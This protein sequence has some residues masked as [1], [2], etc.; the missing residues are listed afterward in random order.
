MAKADKTIKSYKATRTFDAIWSNLLAFVLVALWMIPVLWIVASAFSTQIGYIS[1]TF[2]PTSW[3]F[4]NFV[5]LFTK[6][7]FPQWLLNTAIIA[8]AN[9]VLT[10][11]FTTITA[12]ILSRFRFKSR[13]LLMN[14]SLILGMFPGFMA[15]IAVYLIL[16]MFN[17]I[18]SIW[19]LLIYY[20]AGAGLGFFTCK[21]YFDTLPKDIDESAYLDG[22]SHLRIFF[23]IF[24]PLA[25]PM[26]IYTAL[27]AFMA[28]WADY[29]L[30]SLV[31]T[32]DASKTVAVGLY[33]W[34]DST[35]I[36]VYFTKFA[37][38]CVVVAIPIVTLYIFLQKFFI[39]GISAGAVKG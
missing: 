9:T 22:A 4:D 14:I 19:A 5:D 1:T 20:V 11:F 2:F 24:L 12:Y 13:K 39:E 30:A 38:G 35:M 8:I 16:S 6:T 3:T 27:L 17:L 33:S 28:P 29:I 7:K 31:L 18:G 23:Q 36:N 25:K 10:T 32:S 26:L 15:M 34:M 37:A 21:G